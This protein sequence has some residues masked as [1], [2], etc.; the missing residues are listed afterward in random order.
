MVGRVEGALDRVEDGDPVIVDGEY[1]LLHARPSEEVLKVYEERVESLK[2]RRERYRAARAEPAVTKDGVRVGLFLNAGLL[3]ELTQLDETGAE[4]IGLFRT[5]FQFM[6]SDA[7]PRLDAQ[8]AL[9]RRALDA[10]G[11]R[12]VVFR[13][14]DLGGD[15]VVS[16]TAPVREANPALGWRGLRMGL[17]RPGLT[18]Y[19]LR[20][21]V[22]AAAGRTLNV[23]FPMIAD[24][25]EL[26]AARG[27]LD[28][29]IAHARRFGHPLPAEVNVG[30]MMETPAAAFDP[31]P[32]LAL[33]DFVAVGANDLMQYF[34]AA[35][36]QNARVANRYDVLSRGP[37]KLLRSIAQ[38]CEAAGKPASVCG[39]IAGRPLEACVLASLG[40]RRLSMAPGSVG[41][42]KTALCGLD[43]Q[44]LGAWLA[45]H[46][47]GSSGPSESGG[48]RA[49]LLQ[50]RKSAGLPDDAVDNS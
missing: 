28:R 39:E 8:I 32:V 29:E 33:A 46:L 22:R 42:V 2:R 13:T 20:A 47:D 4:G 17:D 30:F 40:F 15:K 23:L 44:R 25:S 41:P 45:D 18:H 50:A 3:V 14:L 49:A 10:A 21:L 48:L 12:P 11:D 34:F 38:A 7:L 37:L 9:Y 5:E 6:V 19:Q 35:D 36:R 27:I 1:G 43:S 31:G 24:P 16:F 26:A